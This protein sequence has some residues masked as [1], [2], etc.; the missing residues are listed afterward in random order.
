[1]ESL[2]ELAGVQYWLLAVTML[3]AGLALLTF[4]GD[5]LADGAASL[6]ANLRIE[7]VVI[8]ITVVSI[9][10]SAPELFT[11]LIASF[12][13]GGDSLVLGN[14]GGSNLA[15]VALILGLSA[16]VCPIAGRA[17]YYF[18]EIPW[19]ISATAVFIVFCKGGVE[20]KEGALLI[21]MMVI[22]LL[23]TIRLRLVWVKVLGPF[24]K[25]LGIVKDPVS[26]NIGELEDMDEI[27]ERPTHFAL[28]LVLGGTVALLVGA[29]LLVDSAQSIASTLEVS[30]GFVGLTVVA[31][32]TSLPEL[33][34]SIAAARKQQT[35][36]IA[37][38]IFGSNLFNMLFVGGA[39]A[40]ASPIKWD[41][42]LQIEMI[43]MLVVT[44]LLAFVFRKRIDGSREMGRSSGMFL[45]VLYVGI[46]I[47]SASN[48]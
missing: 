37:G 8:G 31:I 3:I 7:P 39:T 16:L 12:R 21:V 28:L 36:L 47:Y 48:L 1:M 18:W 44:L 22:Y 40:I 23:V 11:C 30:Q 32:G 42:S 24:Y 19:L 5:W 29:R 10:T 27:D 20:S 25:I 43:L 9:A 17:R 38:N 26:L 6:A 2:Q 34:A 41:G 35:E 33:A 14:I 13:E 15:N 45:V 46:L 4:G